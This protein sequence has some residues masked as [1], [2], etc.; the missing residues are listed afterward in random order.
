MELIPVLVTSV[1]SLV[2]TCIDLALV[3]ALETALRGT[4][5]TF[6]APYKVMI[7]VQ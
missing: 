6:R 1:F 4:E 2:S 7:R 5:S 3:E